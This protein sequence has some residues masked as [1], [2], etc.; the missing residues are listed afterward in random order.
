MIS[1]YLPLG[2]ALV[3]QM[4]SRCGVVADCARLLGP[5][6]YV[7]RQVLILETRVQFSALACRVVR[8]LER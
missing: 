1:V 4:F 7:A 3:T 8:A 6:I 5:L 2:R